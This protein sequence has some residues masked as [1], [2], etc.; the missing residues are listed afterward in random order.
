ML[1]KGCSDY[2][3]RRGKL[4][5]INKFI[6]SYTIVDPEAGLIIEN[7][8]NERRNGPIKIYRSIKNLK[9]KQALLLPYNREFFSEGVSSDIEI[10]IGKMQSY[11]V[12]M[13]MFGGRDSAFFD[14]FSFGP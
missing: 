9:P 11:S 6:C 14:T 13:M 2:A 10:T 5:Q 8:N 7:V 12:V 4:T 1:E 3:Q